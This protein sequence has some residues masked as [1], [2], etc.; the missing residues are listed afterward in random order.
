VAEPAPRKLR[1]QAPRREGGV[2]RFVQAVK[3]P[4]GLRPVRVTYRL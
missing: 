1:H 4:G 3:H 2:L